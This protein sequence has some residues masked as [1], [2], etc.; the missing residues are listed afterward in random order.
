[1]F[2]ALPKARAVLK[3]GTLY[4]VSGE[5]DWIYFGQVARDKQIGFFRKRARK[6]I[7]PAEILA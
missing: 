5:R 1:M 3:A 4:A 6:L 7:D 2:E